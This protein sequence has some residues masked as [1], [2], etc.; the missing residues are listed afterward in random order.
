VR[1]Q[2]GIGPF[3]GGAQAPSRY[4]VPGTEPSPLSG[5]IHS[6]FETLVSFRCFEIFARPAGW[7]DQELPF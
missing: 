1:A 4:R 3:A 7:N 5:E 2:S 6:F